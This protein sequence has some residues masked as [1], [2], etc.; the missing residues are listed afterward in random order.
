MT[1]SRFTSLALAASVLLF[2]GCNSTST[3][4][5]AAAPASAATVSA[6]APASTDPAA[7]SIVPSANEPKHPWSDKQI[8]TCTVSQCWQL[9]N[10]NEDTF[11]DIIQKLAVI[12]ADNRGLSLPQDA[13][14]GEKVGQSIKAQT[15]ADHQ[16]LLYAVVDNAVRKVGV[17]TATAS[18]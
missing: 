2:A 7:T 6:A 13:A 14:A 8:L 10:R 3:P 18:N 4:P 5:A 11:F 16:Q 12:S 9:A 15:K 17:P 1:T